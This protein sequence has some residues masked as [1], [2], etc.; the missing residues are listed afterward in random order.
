MPS[1]AR[2]LTAA[3]AGS[4][5]GPVLN[6]IVKTGRIEPGRLSISLDSSALGEQLGVQPEH[7]DHDTLT[8]EGDF[9]LRR[10]GNEARL[11]LGDKSSKIDKTLLKNIA[12]GWAWFEEIKT[13]RTLQAIADSAGVTPRQ[14]ASLIDLAFLA[15]DIVQAI[16]DDRQP[17]ALT[18]DSLL[19]SPHRISWAGQ[20]A[21]I[22]TI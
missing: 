14:I 6:A 13:G 7:I 18:T 17:T 2:G 16:V 1:K 11:V 3:L 8:L 15:P 4:G 9:T 19:K 20:R 10:R 21:W 5:R 12:Q 22:S